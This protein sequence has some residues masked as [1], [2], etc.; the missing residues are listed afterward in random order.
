LDCG[1]L[2]Y[3][4]IAAHGHT[5]A[6]SFTLRAF[7]VDIFVDPGT[8]D[9]FSYPEWRNYFRSTRAHN[10]VVVDKIDQSVMLGPF[11]WGDRAKTRCIDWNPNPEGG[12]VVGEHDG[13]MRLKDPIKH[14]RTLDLDAGSRILTI[15]D[16][17]IAKGSHEIGIYL[18]LSEECVIFKTQSNRYEIDV[19]GR[20]IVIEVDSKFSTEISAGGKKPIAGWMSKCYHK[21]VASTS[22]VGRG[23]YHGDTSFVC[24]VI[25]GSHE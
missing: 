6:L 23:I 5:D 20:K 9:Y 25:M 19:R 8:Y 13:Y 14:R 17:I 12:R 24:R 2:G 22:I 7:G 15:R 11:M 3:K 18:H 16:E 10:T 1:E 21:K 4:S